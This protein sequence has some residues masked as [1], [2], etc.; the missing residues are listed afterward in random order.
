MNQITH[1][2]LM[3]VMLV[4]M[5]LTL[6]SCD[7]SGKIEAV[8]EANSVNSEGNKSEQPE[9]TLT[10][11]FTEIPTSSK[12]LSTDDPATSEDTGI[13]KEDNIAQDPDD[14]GNADIAQPSDTGNG[15]SSDSGNVENKENTSAG[16]KN[17][18]KEISADNGKSEI[19]ATNS[20]NDKNQATEKPNNTDK[21]KSTKKPKNTDKP[22]ATE[23]SKNA[24]KP[25]ATEKPKEDK[26][27]DSTQSENNAGKQTASDTSQTVSDT[28]IDTNKDAN[29]DNM[30]TEKRI[31]AID[32]GHQRKGN[33]DTEPIG[34]GAKATKAKVSSG[35]QGRY[36]KVPEYELNLV[37]AK[38]VKEELINRGYE[39]VM[40]RET[41]D[42]DLSNK[43]RADIANKSGADIFIRIHANG[44]ENPSVNGTSTLYPSK[45]NPYIADLSAASLKLS[46]AIV[47]AI[48]ENTGSKNRGAIAHDDMSGINWSKIPVTIIEMGY[49]TNEKEDKL[50]QTEDYQNKIAQGI[51]DG[52][53]KYFK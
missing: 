26:S 16:V 33:Y 24:D 11:E 6:I 27:N 8:N 1:R 35:T 40:I 53:D 21:T 45:K 43:E 29:K 49:M 48:C 30:V 7:K 47:D 23:K 15:N 2:L 22:D 32:A 17:E 12:E 3:I 31:V 37:V 9:E 5:A 13:L 18:N 44:S 34:P 25:N 19:K 42:V 51:C 36:T 20:D 52:I 28:N 41:H 10:E 46:Q 14:T 38:K 50:M 39:V 4:I